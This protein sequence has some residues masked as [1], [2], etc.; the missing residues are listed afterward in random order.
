M[1][2]VG[3]I[4]VA[5]DG[6]EGAWR[7]LEFGRDLAR[8]FKAGLVLLHVIEPFPEGDLGNFDPPLSEQY[9]RRMKQATD[10]LARL[11][12][13]F[14]LP[15]AEQVVEMG[16]P[17]DVICREAAERRADLIVLGWHGHRLG[18]RL[19]IGSVGGHVMNAASCS[20]TVVH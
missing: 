10:Y 19:L 16:R 6:S 8:A 13:E 2:S 9:A 12:G 15:D 4:L 11:A 5:V 7:A 1:A 17:G 20:V 18:T 14:G 3:R